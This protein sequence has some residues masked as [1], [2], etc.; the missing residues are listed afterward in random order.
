LTDIAASTATTATIS[1][2]GTVT[3]SLETVGDHD[4]YAITLTAG[5]TLV[6]S[7]NGSGLNPDPDSYLNLRDASGNLIAWND[8]S[9][10]SL[11]SSIYFQV[12][13]SGTYYVDA[14]AWDMQAQDST[15]SQ[16]NYITGTYSLSVQTYAAPPVYTINQI[17]NQLTNGYWTDF[18]GQGPHHFNVTQ[19]GT[20]TVNISTLNAAEQTLAR[21]ALG[22]WHDIIG[23]NF[24][25]VTTGG[26][27][28]FSDAED[29]SS[30]DGIASTSSTSSGGITTTA[31]IDIS[32]SWVNTYGTSLDSYSFQTYLHEIGHAL[33]LGHAGDYNGDATY[34]TD[35]I[36]A[37]DSWNT[38]VMS[39]FSPTDNFYFANQGFSQNFLVTPMDADI[40]AMQNLYGL[41]TTTRT[42]NTTYGF[43]SNAGNLFNASLYSDVA[44]TIYDSG[45]TDTLDYSGFNDNQLI[46]LNP[47]TFMNVGTGVGNLMIA[48][49]VTI[50]NAIGGTGNDTITGNAVANTLTGNAGNDT[51]NG[52]AGADTLIGGS[53][54]DTLNGGSGNDVFSD[55]LGG[56]N[57]DTISDLAVGDTIVFTDAT[58]AGFSFTLT[59]NTLTY[60]GGSLTLQGPPGGQLVASAAAGGGVQLSLAPPA[61]PTEGD[62]TLNGT[63]LADQLSGLGG[64][65]T[66]NGL[67]GNDI[68]DGGAGAD[69]MAG[70]LGDDTYVVDN[71]GDVVTENPG[72]GTDLVNSSISWVLGANF[73]NLTLTGTAAINGTGNALDNIITGNS[74]ANR[75]DGGVGADHLIGGEGNDIYYVDNVG[76]V[77]TEAANQGADLVFSAIDYVL[78]ANVENLTLTG[79]ALNGTGNTFANIVQGNGSD[80][81]LSGGTGDDTLYGFAGRD[82][83]DGGLGNDHLYGG[84]GNDIYYVNSQSDVVTENAGEGTDLVVSAVSV[85]L[86]AN[87]ENLTLVGTDPI[88]GIGSAVDNLIQGNSANNSLSGAAGNDT[89][90]GYGGDDRLDGGTGNDHL[91]GGIGN[92][93]Y[94][95][96]SQ[97]DVVFENAGE[98]IDSVFSS[99]SVTLYPN[100]ENLTLVGSALNG[101]GNGSDNVLR[102]TSADNMLSGLGGND[103]LNGLDGND[104]LI[105]GAGNDWLNGGNGTDTMSG[106]V[107]NDTYIVDN[108]GDVVT[109]NPGEGTDLV[110]SSI[111]YTL[112][113]DVENLTLT[114]STAING[115]GNA[116]DNVI[117]GNGAANLL[118]GSDG[119][120]TLIGGGGADMMTGGIGND[121]FTFTD[122]S[123]SLPGSADTI[124]DFTSSNGEGSDDQID[125]SAI[126]AD[127]SLAGDQAFALNTSAPLTPAAHS[128]WLAATPN[129][130]GS[131]DWVLY[132]DVNGDTTADFEIHFHTAT[133]TLFF[134]DITP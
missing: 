39:Y 56:H 98:G 131:E 93:I 57:G 54:S 109:E 17:A 1:V 125:L 21:A 60:A 94:Y 103:T 22:Q 118:S 117:T 5:Q 110:Q 50:E 27:I 88:N 101:T 68:L 72:E 2:G 70:G 34:A 16:G 87:V 126:D 97:S 83:L 9:G 116:L 90:Y 121:T 33:G 19:G 18:D 20:I 14:G 111:T 49:G 129:G 63:E 95:V 48:R 38:S 30:P 133:Q 74:A 123:D 69:T 43:N 31:D 106:G 84:A 3:G 128:I 40:V 28:T 120:D 113:S 130:D 4:W 42:G 76:D 92:D 45:G 107:G 127:T 91:Y 35:A 59:G 32:A 66:I 114:G 37:N 7:E 134:D 80:N 25:E 105:G 47:E 62:D 52:G 44:Y 122:I 102:G 67:D 85:T 65:D 53:G 79:A 81:I 119:N 46:N 89:L 58:L 96:D 55:T 132:G 82:K 23:V 115:T 112:G 100:V 51:V 36:F 99:V 26:Q 75:L 104:T 15:P 13:T 29:S 73:E 86:Y 64:N 12:T 124:A 41:S 11:N 6:F 61:G 24:Q 10:G 78:P 108:A 77:V 8:D 71:A